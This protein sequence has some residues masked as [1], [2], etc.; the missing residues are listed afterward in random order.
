[1][2][3]KEIRTI[4]QHRHR[5]EVRR[6]LAMRIESQSR[7]LNFIELVRQRRGN[8][9]ADI[10]AESCRGQWERGNRGEWGVWK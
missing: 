3:R 5:C 10:L 2:T 8:D 9:A 1:M 7:A 4:E 6:V